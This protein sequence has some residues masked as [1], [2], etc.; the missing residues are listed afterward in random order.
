MR[1][2]GMLA[3][4]Y[5]GKEIAMDKEWQEGQKKMHKLS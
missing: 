3:P 5:S 4:R 1:L 2:D